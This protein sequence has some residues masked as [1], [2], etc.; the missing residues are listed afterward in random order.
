MAYSMRTRETLLRAALAAACLLG[1]ADRAAA[2]AAAEAAPMK[3]VPAAR[4]TNA[5]GAAMLGAAW[6]GPRAVAVGDHG[7]VLLSD[8]QGRS[9]RQ[10]RSVPVS[11]MLTSVSFAD[12]QR[13]WAVGHWG[14]ILHTADGGESWTLQRLAPEEDRPLFAVH[15]FDAQQGVAVGLWSLVLT[16]ADGGRTWSQQTLPPP[17]GSRRAD[18]NLLSLF[19]DA[20]GR[21]Y[22][23]AERGMVLRSDDRGRT[24]SY[25]ETG[26]AGSLWSGIAL[27]DGT[28]VAGGLRGSV[29]RSGDEGRSWSRIET[30]S[31]SSVTG[32]AVQPSGLLAVGLDGLQLLSRDAGRAFAPQPRRDRLSLTAALARPAAPPILFSRAGVVA[33]TGQ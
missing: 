7:V 5:A 24:W 33:P 23:P 32:F 1:G 16:T 18:L 6:A 4:A 27:P 2:Q 9:F 14:A 19:A 3:P 22:A 11:S 25:L 29:Y 21:L 26:Y 12:A 30:G 15:F 28:L 31:K 8:D 20:K 13:G 10:A 17:P